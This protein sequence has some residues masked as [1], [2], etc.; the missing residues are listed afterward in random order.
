MTVKNLKEAEER[1]RAAMQPLT[2]QGQG[3]SPGI[4]RMRQ[5]ARQTRPVP[6]RRQL[7]VAR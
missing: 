2:A 1:I 6:A 3:F 4:Q 7:P 5:G